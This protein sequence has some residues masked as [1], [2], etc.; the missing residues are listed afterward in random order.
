MNG[1]YDVREPGFVKVYNADT[2]RGIIIPD[3]SESEP[4]IV[5]SE[6]LG[7]DLA[8]LRSGQRVVFDRKA[9]D[10]AACSHVELEAGTD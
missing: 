2:G 1:W 3:E 8:L 7:N 5:G 4:V 10:R 6:A 9:T